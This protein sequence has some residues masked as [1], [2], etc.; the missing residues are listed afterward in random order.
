MKLA[1][2]LDR[3][4]PDLGRKPRHHSRSRVWHKRLANR[5]RRRAERIDPENC[6]RRFT[7]GW[8]D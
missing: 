2:Q 7:R 6:Q 4:R 8:Y 1:E 3:L 5:A